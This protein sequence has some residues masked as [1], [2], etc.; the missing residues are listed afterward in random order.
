VPD[1]SDARSHAVVLTPE[2]AQRLRRAFEDLREERESL[3]RIVAA[4]DR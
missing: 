4:L 3:A 2:G 1:E